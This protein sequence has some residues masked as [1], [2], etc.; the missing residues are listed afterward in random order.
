MGNILLFCHKRVE[1]TVQQSISCFSGGHV[2][3][4]IWVTTAK[5]RSISESVT[6]DTDE[7]LSWKKSKYYW[8]YLLVSSTNSTKNSLQKCNMRHCMESIFL[9]GAVF[10]LLQVIS[11]M[12]WWI[13]FFAPP[14]RYHHIDT[15]SGLE[16]AHNHNS[17]VC[18]YELPYLT[19]TTVLNKLVYLTGQL[20]ILYENLNVWLMIVS[21]VY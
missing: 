11:Q 19:Y 1:A 3:C 15:P 12:N 20:F 18:C 17:Q 16:A 2:S 21:N 4:P 6:S 8:C 7:C 13:L 14:I 9:Q 10:L 5:N